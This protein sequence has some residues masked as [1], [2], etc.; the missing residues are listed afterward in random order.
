[1]D[2]SVQNFQKCDSQMRFFT[3]NNGQNLVKDYPLCMQPRWNSSCTDKKL[4]KTDFRTKRGT[5]I[6]I[7]LTKTFS[8]A[9]M[10]IKALD[11]HA[12]GEKHKKHLP[13]Q[14]TKN[15]I[16]FHPVGEKETSATGNQNLK[17]II[18]IGTGS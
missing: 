8:V 5:A 3:V 9:N 12:N 17:S 15:K 14:D 7:T 16:G 18:T 1:M 10:C 13:C 6:V 11:V 4:I 2:I